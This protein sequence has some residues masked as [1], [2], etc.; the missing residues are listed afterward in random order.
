MALGMAKSTL[1]SL[2]LSAAV[3]LS[4]SL[5]C[6]S[7]C[8]LDDFDPS[9]AISNAAAAAYNESESFSSV[10][11]LILLG[12]FESLASEEEDILFNYIS[13]KSNLNSFA[14]NDQETL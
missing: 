5:L 4:V 12:C 6:N 11:F 1:L 8:D 10:S 7:S 9:F 3:P 2:A 14:V 13:I